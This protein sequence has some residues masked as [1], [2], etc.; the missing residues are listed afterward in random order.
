MP[1][2]IFDAVFSVVLI[3]KCLKITEQPVICSEFHT[4]GFILIW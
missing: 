4:F 3:N 2:G 1:L